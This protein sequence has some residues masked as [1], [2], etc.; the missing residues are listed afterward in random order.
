MK[1]PHVKG[2]SFYISIYEENGL[3]NIR[4]LRDI[5][6]SAIY[7]INVFNTRLVYLYTSISVVRCKYL[8]IIYYYYQN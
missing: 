1:F 8:N 7:V 3:I 5:R 2:K 6:G 4:D